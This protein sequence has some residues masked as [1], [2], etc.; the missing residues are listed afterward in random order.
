MSY[1]TIV[2]HADWSA[3][4]PT[5]IGLAAAIAKA[6]DAHLIG[7]ATTGISRFMYPNGRGELAGTVAENYVDVL[8]EQANHSLA[9]FDALCRD[10]AVRSFERRLLNDDPGGALVLLGR[11]C[12]LVVVSQTDPDEP[13]PGVVRD[14]PEYVMLNCARPTL[15]VP[16]AGGQTGL[17][18]EALLAWNGSREATRAMGDAI[19]LLRHAA[20]A[21]VA[22][23]I[24]DPAQEN[25]A[26]DYADLT[27]Y[28]ARHTVKAETLVQQSELD[29][30]RALLALAAHLGC[31]LIVMGGYGHARYRELLLGGV[32]RTMLSSMTTPVLMS[33]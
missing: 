29:A 30:G 21:T 23:F 10:L 12:D 15:V 4:A 2:V 3:H 19:P 1:K 7:A 24:T 20:R 18:G 17:D 11:F 5:R 22:H 28:L 13:A 31:G 6:E 32:T 16:S 33:H 27:A 25:P 14:L 8:Y 26:A 9:Q